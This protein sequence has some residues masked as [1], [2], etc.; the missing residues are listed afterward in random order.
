MREIT[1]RSDRRIV[2]AE[3]ERRAV[4]RGFWEDV[5]KNQKEERNQL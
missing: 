5:F 4:H 3:G 2:D 1:E